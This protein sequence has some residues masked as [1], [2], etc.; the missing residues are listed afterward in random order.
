MTLHKILMKR[1]VE[2]KVKLKINELFTG[3]PTLQQTKLHLDALW[4]PIK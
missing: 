1:F 2:S 4:S 3:R